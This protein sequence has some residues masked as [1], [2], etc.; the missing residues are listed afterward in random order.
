MTRSRKILIGVLLF[1]TILLAVVSAYVALNLRDVS[2]PDSQVSGVC[3]GH[4]ECTG[5][6]SAGEDLIGA[7][8]AN[9]TD[10]ANSFC[11]S[12][13]QTLISHGG[14]KA[15]AGQSGGGSNNTCNQQSTAVH[16]RGQQI[17]HVID[18]AG[19]S[20]E[21]RASNGNACMCVP[22]TGVLCSQSSTAVNCRGQGVNHV[23]SNGRVCVS[24][25]SIGSDGRVMCST[26][27]GQ[28]DDRCSSDAQCGLAG[29]Y[30]NSGGACVYKEPNGAACTRNSMCNSNICSGN[31]CVASTPGQPPV[32]PTANLSIGD[33]CSL[34]S[35]GQV[36][37][38]SGSASL[39]CIQCGAEHGN[40]KAC[41][42][43]SNANT[44][45]FACGSPGI[46]NLTP[47]PSGVSCPGFSHLYE[48]QCIP[49]TVRANKCRLDRNPSSNNNV[50]QVNADSCGASCKWARDTGNISTAS[51]RNT[52]YTF[53]LM[54]GTS[55]SHCASGQ[56]ICDGDAIQGSGFVGCGNVVT[57]GNGDA[58]SNCYRNS[59]GS[60]TCIKEGTS[61][62]AKT[63]CLT[64][65]GTPPTTPPTVPPTNPP[66]TPTCPFP[67][68]RVGVR[69]H[70]TSDWR[71]SLT[72][73]A[74]QT[75]F[76]VTAFQC[77]SAEGNNCTQVRN[78]IVRLT[79]AGFNGTNPLGGQTNQTSANPL[80]TQAINRQ[81]SNHGTITVRVQ[82]PDFP[83]DPACTAT[84]TI[85]VPQLY[86]GDRTCQS[87]EFCERAPS[88]N[89]FVACAGNHAGIPAGTVVSDC[90]Q[91]ATSAPGNPAPPACTFCGDGVVNGGEQCDYNAPGA[92]NCNT[93]C[94]T[95]TPVCLS[96]DSS[97]AT[98]TI[99]IDGNN[100]VTYTL[101]YRSANTT[102]PFPN[103][104]LM[105]QGER[106]RDYYRPSERIVRPAD[107][108]NNPRF[109][110]SSSTWVYT[111]VWQA[112]DTTGTVSNPLAAGGPLSVTVLTDRNNGATTIGTAAC[113]SQLTLT[114]EP[115][116]E[117][118]N[119]VLVKDSAPVCLETG[120]TQVDYTITIENIGEA[121]GV[122]DV[123]RDTLDSRFI[124]L[125]I[126]P[127]D[128]N[129]AFGAYNNGVIT[130]TGTV[131]DRTFAPG[132]TKTYRY[133]VVIPAQH[134]G[135]F[136]SDGVDNIAEIEF[137]DNQ[138]QFEVNTPIECES[139]EV[140]EIPEIPGTAIF[141]DGFNPTNYILLGMM[142]ILLGGIVLKTSA[143]STIVLPGMLVVQQRLSYKERK[144]KSFEEKLI[145][146]VRNK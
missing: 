36:C 94:Q 140:P 112:T 37:G 76:N 106:G 88:G 127:T 77:T 95:I 54:N 2:E 22:T 137:G 51:N 121:E 12:Q 45:Y 72:L 102:N 62:G 142:F 100:T 25:G 89:G 55:S 67:N 48:E 105:V 63:Q 146:K 7:P 6:V 60:L 4:I 104:G 117:E 31:R 136:A 70:G 46:T 1:F 126:T 57:G 83:N 17:G 41:G 108:V 138:L 73:S 107:I 20:C 19:G 131:A 39:R 26:G 78:A 32:T 114:Q 122:I 28:P 125:G 123:L 143:W 74:S 113:Q 58:C 38:G 8:F 34:F 5:N 144:R 115:E 79:G 135:Q 75:Q 14:D 109:I 99:D 40:R 47:I 56:R 21:C 84:A 92:Q 86:C 59:N 87:G 97:N 124:S 66:G 96:L 9:C 101:R 50:W 98:G 29:T 68:T 133:R 11:Q 90:R 42:S 116:P 35:A 15:C 18:V 141:G 139:P 91:V 3:C 119:F 69:V 80:R 129:P 43:T 81:G 111:F 71:S 128:I 103:I 24:T 13:G 110:A 30:C 61:C 27:E 23:L 52:N 85:V 82:H 49:G 145:D 93:S 16:C 118:P 44:Q 64:G 53:C 134:V 65:G 132:Q 120:D 10:R 130:W 33:D